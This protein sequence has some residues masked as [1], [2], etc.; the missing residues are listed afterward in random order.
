MKNFLSLFLILALLTFSCET[1]FS[2]DEISTLED[3]SLVPHGKEGHVCLTMEA[4]D[5]NLQ[6]NPQL[7][8]NMKR[9]EDFTADFIKRGNGRLVNG[10]IEIPVVYHVIY[11]TAS[12][13]LP[14]SQL[15]DQIDI[16]NEDFNLQNP[17]RGSIPAEFAAIEANVGIRFVL[18]Q[19][20][21]VQSNKRSWNIGGKDFDAMK[22]TSSGGSDVVNPQEFL[23]VWIV[24]NMPYR[25]GTVLGYA[26]FPG[27]D[28]ATDG[29]V[30]GSRFVGYSG[31]GFT[32]R[33]ATHEVGHW[34]NLRHI[35]GDDGS[36]CT[37]SDFVDD[38]PNQGGSYSGQCPPYPS[39]SCGSNDN[40]QNYMGYVDDT[41]MSMFTQGQKTRMDAVFAG[42]RATMAD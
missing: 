11:R 33:T 18:E 19:V 6:A 39:V 20:I 16:L 29:I 27:G 17:E 28:W 30:L 25:G 31:N 14:L 4:L 38:T 40:T 15:Q 22:F 42:F 8:E 3:V 26:Q 36:G 1:Q 24:N 35:W 37:G 13:N 34:L 5:R 10:V 7:A 21:R 41:C 12:E 2:D 9:I 23:N 32:G